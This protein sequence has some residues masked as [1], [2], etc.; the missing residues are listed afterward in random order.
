MRIFFIEYIFFLIGWIW[1]YQNEILLG[2]CEIVWI[3]YII[4]S[5]LEIED[6]DKVLK[7]EKNDR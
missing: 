2:Y 5:I 3:Y 4:E 7:E 6:I 1:I